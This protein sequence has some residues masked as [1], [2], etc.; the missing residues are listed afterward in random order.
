[1]VS[2]QASDLKPLW[3][4]NL[5]RKSCCA[6]GQTSQEVH[7]RASPALGAMWAQ[8]PAAWGKHRGLRKGWCPQL[9]TAGGSTVS[10]MPTATSAHICAGTRGW[11]GCAWAAALLM[12]C[13]CCSPRS[14][15]SLC[16]QRHR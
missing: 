1:M 14:D 15:T 11:W 8:A 2:F 5:L 16:L 7:G 13:A 12:L 6:L 4:P 3:V 9:P 10:A